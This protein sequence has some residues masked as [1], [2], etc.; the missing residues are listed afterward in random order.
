[1]RSLFL[2]IT[3]LCLYSCQEAKPA[4]VSDFRTGSFKTVLDDRQIVS[5]AWRNDTVQIE[6]YSGKKD[7]FDIRWVDPFEYVLVKTNP[8]TLLDSTPFHVKI[9]S[10]K[11][12][13][14]TFRAYYRG[15]NFKQTGTAFKLDQLEEN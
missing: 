11:R 10:I 14:Y 12:D 6:T 7:T 4:K 5:T 2:I 1:M 3:V 13:S 15:S 8:R 9:T